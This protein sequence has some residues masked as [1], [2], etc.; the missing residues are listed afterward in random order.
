MRKI[1]LLFLA[2]LSTHLLHAQRITKIVLLGEKGIVQDIKLARSFIVMKKYPDGSYQRLNYKKRGPLES[3]QTYGDS[4]LSFFEGN[5]YKYNENGNLSCKGYYNQ[6]KK[7]SLW[8]Y[9]N[10][11]FKIVKQEIYRSGELI[12]TI[13]SDTSRSFYTMKGFHHIDTEASFPGGAKAWNKYLDKKFYSKAFETL[14][15]DNVITKSVK[16]GEVIIF[17]RIDEA[18]N[19]EDV[20][21]RKSVEYILDEEAIRM[22]RNSPLWNPAISNGQ[23]VKSYRS[24]S[25]AFGKD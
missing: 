8:S 2:F 9:Y 13:D 21:L 3:L 1:T 14:D 25:I 5:Y 18:G 11:T 17:F 24:Q 12:Q 22:I 10:D 6:N 19:V 15:E 7:D 23:K 20:G 16:G 4:S